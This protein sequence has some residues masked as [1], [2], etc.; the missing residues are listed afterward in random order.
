MAS[1]KRKTINY[2]TTAS[3]DTPSHEKNDV[4]NTIAIIGF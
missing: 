2:N 4:I 1:H 3:N